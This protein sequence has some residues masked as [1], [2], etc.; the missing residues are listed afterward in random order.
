M[1]GPKGQVLSSGFSFYLGSELV[2]SKC[3]EKGGIDGLIF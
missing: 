3:N 2:D 1:Q